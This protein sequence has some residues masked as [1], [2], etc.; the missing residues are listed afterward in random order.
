MS[1]FYFTCCSKIVTVIIWAKGYVSAILS[2]APKLFID[3]RFQFP[4]SK[5]KLNNN[6]LELAGMIWC[7]F[8]FLLGLL[9]AASHARF[10]R[11]FT[12]TPRASCVKSF[13][14]THP[15]G[16]V[17]SLFYIHHAHFCEKFLLHSSCRLCGEFF[18]HSSY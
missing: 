9:R 4:N 11:S 8:N 2:L 7:H 14:N 10:V 16:F 6:K 17:R 15:A 13:S 1:Q 3:L 12:C 5:L 18:L